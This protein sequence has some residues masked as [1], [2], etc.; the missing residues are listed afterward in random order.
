MYKVVGL[1][2]RRDGLSHEEFVA[3]WD[4]HVP[5]ARELPNV[6]RYTRSVPL[7]PAAAPFDGIAEMYFD[8]PEACRAAFESDAGSRQFEDAARFVAM[9]DSDDPESASRR[10]LMETLVEVRTEFDDCE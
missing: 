2:V 6:R 1:L 4:E 8:S 10:R 9:P 5:V 3:R 7:D